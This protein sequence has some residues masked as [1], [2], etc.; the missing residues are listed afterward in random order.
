MNVEIRYKMGRQIKSLEDELL[1]LQSG[2]N[3]GK[4][5]PACD[6]EP[7]VAEENPVAKTGLGAQ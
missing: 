7:A 3:V 6:N 4:T 2:Q 5:I 1:K